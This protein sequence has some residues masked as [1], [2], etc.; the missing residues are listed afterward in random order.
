ME[1]LPRPLWIESDS[2]CILDYP[3]LYAVLED[4]IDRYREA[5]IWVLVHPEC[6][7]MHLDNFLSVVVGINTSR[8]QRIDLLVS[9]TKRHSANATGGEAEGLDL[10]LQ[11]LENDKMLGPDV[12]LSFWSPRDDRIFRFMS[13][14]TGVAAPPAGDVPANHQFMHRYEIGHWEDKFPD[15]FTVDPWLPPPLTPTNEYYHVCDSLAAHEGS[16]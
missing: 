14:S 3:A 2:G 15:W 16:K 11:R 12:V 6:H 4:Y 7:Y 8:L 10:K 5:Y 9:E 1:N 13:D